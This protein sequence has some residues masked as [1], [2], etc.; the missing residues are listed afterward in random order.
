MTEIQ[1]D[2]TN[3]SSAGSPVEESAAMATASQAPPSV[4]TSTNVIVNTDITTVD[5]SA[6]NST[7]MP[8]HVTPQPQ[9]NTTNSVVNPIPS[10][11]STVQQAPIQQHQQMNNMVPKP[12][13]NGTP[14]AQQQTLL[15]PVSAHVTNV[16][17]APTQQATTMYQQAT[18]VGQ[19]HFTGQHGQQTTAVPIGQ[20]IGQP[21][22]VSCAQVRPSGGAT[23]QQVQVIPQQIGTGQPFLAS[24]YI[25]QQLM[26]QSKSLVK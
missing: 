17:F 8:L 23:L 24:P 20:A 26:F 12:N 22:A 4:S 14:L 11:V 18:V 2:S 13:G 3:C 5:T 7:T 15:N 6:I 10:N 25:Q 9:A 19:P 1:A 16:T 21:V